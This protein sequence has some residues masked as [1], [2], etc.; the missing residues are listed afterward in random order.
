MKTAAIYARVSTED[1]RENGTSLESQVASCQKYADLNGYTVLATLKESKSGASLN[2]PMLDE[3][4]EMV[5]HGEIK[6]IIFHALDRLSRDETDTLILAREWRLA[7]VEMRCATVPLEDTVQGQFLLTMLAAVGKLERAGIIERTMRGKR[8]TVRNGLVMRAKS[9]TFGYTFHDGKY[10]INEAEAVW[11][12]RMFH[13]Y[14]VEGLSLLRISQHLSMS[15]VGCKQGGKWAPATVR[16]MLAN[17]AYIGEYWWN[18]NLPRAEWI[19]PVAIPAL[20]SRET[21]EA[22]IRQIDYNKRNCRRKCKTE[23]LLRGM[24]VCESCGR[25]L[26]GDKKVKATGTYTYYKCTNK[27]TSNALADRCNASPVSGGRAEAQVWDWVMERLSN[28]ALIMEIAQGSDQADRAQRERDEAD[29]R[30]LLAVRIELDRD[31]NK[32]IEL[33]TNDAISLDKFRERKSV[34]EE[35][36]AGV[37]TAIQEIEARQAARSQ[38]IEDVQAA[39]DICRQIQSG[40]PRI[41]A[42]L[43]FDEKRELLEALHVKATAKPDG[44]ILISAQITEDLLRLLTPGAPDSSII[45]HD[46]HNN[47]GGYRGREDDTSPNIGETIELANEPG[48]RGGGQSKAIGWQVLRRPRAV[49]VPDRGLLPAQPLPPAR[50]CGQARS[51]RGRPLNKLRAVS[52]GR[53]SLCQDA[54]FRG[55]EPARSRTGPVRRDLRC[56]GPPGGRPRPCGLPDSVGGHPHVPHLPARPFD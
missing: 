36:A 34:R 9:D 54:P 51:R 55:L 10:V 22:A 40:M 12:R 13:W 49:C 52:G 31:E 30:A 1:Q 47:R 17:Q 3:L 15:G 42:E 27:S 48:G 2:R 45:E 5:R 28:P 53:L 32:Q 41:T 11:V 56:P 35:R 6:V 4:R 29:L 50:V 8:Q 20:I 23:Y 25:R 37:E 38:A 14:C 21:Y 19:G 16:L 7:G 46:I 39:L 33:F 43:S 18:R 26:A 44:N 24:L